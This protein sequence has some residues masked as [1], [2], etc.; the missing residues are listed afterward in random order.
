LI[1]WVAIFSSLSF[2]GQILR[3]WIVFN[4]LSFIFYHGEIFYVKDI[5]DKKVASQNQEVEG[6][7]AGYRL[8]RKPLYHELKYYTVLSWSW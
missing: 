8:Q 6:H 4:K 3:N 5:T 7:I 1:R 2:I